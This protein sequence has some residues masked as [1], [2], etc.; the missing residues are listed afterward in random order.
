MFT[1]L[2]FKFKLP[3]LWLPEPK[4]LSLAAKN[5]LPTVGNLCTTVGS[6]WNRQ[7][8]WD[9]KLK[10]DIDWWSLSDVS[11]CLAIVRHCVNFSIC[12]HMQLSNAFSQNFQSVMVEESITVQ[13]L[14]LLEN[15]CSC[16]KAGWKNRIDCVLIRQVC[17]KIQMLRIDRSLLTW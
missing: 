17:L 15:N 16:R 1:V 6:F 10:W 13:K 11:W 14:D 8:L 9:P 5:L 7:W 4:S 3:L 12:F 2:S